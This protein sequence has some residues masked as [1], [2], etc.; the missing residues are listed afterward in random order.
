MKRGKIEI[1]LKQLLEGKR[2]SQNKLSKIADMQRTQ[3]RN[4]YNNEITRFDAD[5]LVRIC[6]A[7]ECEL[8]DL[9]E[10]VPP[11]Q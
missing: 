9:L 2:I 7:L 10:F 3:V 6:T 8:G 1:K 4:Y 5:V 11:E